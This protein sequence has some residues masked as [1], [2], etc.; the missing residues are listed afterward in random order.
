[1]AANQY[2]NQVQNVYIA[3]YG[4]PADP[5][6]LAYWANR[7]DQANGNLNEIISAFGNSAEASSL[8]GNMSFAQQVQ[9]IY[10]Q[11]FGRQ[12]EQAGLD[13]YVG[14]LTDGSMSR[15]SVM[16]DIL[17]GAQNEDKAVLENKQAVASAFTAHLNES[18]EVNAYAGDAAANTVRDFMKDVNSSNLNS[19]QLQID[20]V[21]VQLVGTSS[22]VEPGV[23]NLTSGT[24]SLSGKMFNAPVGYT[25]GGNDRVNTLQDEDKLIGLGGNATLNVTLGTPND[26][27][28]SIVTPE[29]HNIKTINVDFTS[30]VAPMEL[31]LQ[32]APGVEYV[33]VN[34]ISGANNSA[35][36]GDMRSIPLNVTLNN[37]SAQTDTVTFDFAAHALDKVSNGT[38]PAAEGY[39][40][41]NVMGITV[42]NTDVDRLVIGE[43]DK[44]QNFLEKLRIDSAGNQVP[45]TIGELNVQGL[46]Q[47]VVSGSSNLTIGDLTGM[48]AS[49]RS[50]DLRDMTG[51]LTLSDAAVDLIKVDED[52]LNAGQKIDGKDAGSDVLEIFNTAN[53]SPADLA[54]FKN[55]DKIVFS[56]GNQSEAQ[57]LTLKLND[58]VLDAFDTAGTASLAT[59]E[60]V[61]IALG[62]GTAT[63]KVVL[64]LTDVT[65]PGKFLFEVSAADLVNFQLIDPNGVFP[66]VPVV[67]SNPVFSIAGITVVEGGAAVVT[68]TRDDATEAADITVQTTDGTATSPADYTSVGTTISFAAGETSKTVSIA[69]IDDAE[70]EADETFTV[71][72]SA[73]TRGTVNAAA[74]TAT[75]T[76][77]D[78]DAPPAPTP[79]FS[80]AGAS[81]AEEAGTVTLTIT[82][83]ITTGAATVNVATADGT[84]IAGSDYTAATQT[85]SFADGAATATVTVSILNDALPEAAE[86]FTVA[87]SNP[88]VGT[89]SAAA[90]TATVT[91]TDTDVAGPV[92][93]TVIVTN[94]TDNAGNNATED[95][96]VDNVTFVIADGI[97]ADFTYT[98][99]GFAA[100]DVLDFEPGFGGAS[101]VNTNF[102]DGNI[103]ISAADASG[104]IATIVLTGVVAENGSTFIVDTTTFNNT[105]GAGSLI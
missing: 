63:K 73:P 34:R 16:L 7:L 5:E 103:E 104:N 38:D 49:L 17:N 24:D 45:N 18:H 96:S 79:V 3:Y 88:S 77:T 99:A 2:L 11:L 12:P 92:S 20:P 55:I 105:F 75:V 82:R 1:M 56:S 53:V 4:R 36:I 91:I 30:S 67:I 46:E 54:G 25:P 19:K 51:K 28:A 93:R 40:D 89:I 85:V 52:S 6:G 86:T 71:A 95:A 87:L 50:L 23:V 27:G 66:G 21:I 35:T 15:T 62:A 33:N 60:T 74:A 98:I 9:N 76:I 72:I 59:P 83:D 102:A 69:T 22:P 84:A 68:I 43:V 97:G 47:L 31:N 44:Q 90:G 64:D 70:V 100:G 48:D 29:L 10:M 101:V 13:F 61:K 65:T 14:K 42:N 32:D 94:G 81:V 41:G 80:I 78:N 26:N 37:T 57:V 58:A 39:S 8:Y